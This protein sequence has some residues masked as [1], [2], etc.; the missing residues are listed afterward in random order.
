VRATGPRAAAA[1]GVQAVGANESAPRVGQVLEELDEKLD[2]GE[3]L[4]VGVEIVGVILGFDS[5]NREWNEGTQSKL[6][7]QPIYRDA[8]V[9]G[10]FLAGLI[11]ISVT[12][13]SILLVITGLGLITL[14]VVPGAEE[15]LRIFL[16]FVVSL[17]YASFWLGVAIL[18][19][20]LVPLGASAV[21]RA[22]SPQGGESNTSYVLRVTELDAPSPS[23]PPCACTW[24]PWR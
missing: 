12:L 3:D 11:L 4:R 24:I 23:F 18:F 10:K 2:G 15:L 9:N 13:L 21:S 5:I 16:H 8:V 20:F 6:L 1:R 14:G 19:S 17:L 22:A 7:A